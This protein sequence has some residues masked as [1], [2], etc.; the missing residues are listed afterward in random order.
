[1]GRARKLATAVIV[2]T[3]LSGARTVVAQQTTLTGDTIGAPEPYREAVRR[4][5]LRQEPKIVGGKLAPSGA[6][7]WQASLEVAWISDPFRSHYCGGSVLSATWILTAAHCVAGL[8]PEKVTVTA[9]TNVLGVGGVRVN[10]K[11]LIVRADYNKDTSDN[12]IALIEL[13]EPLPVGERLKAIAVLDAKTEGDVL[14]EDTPMTTVGWGRTQEG[15]SVVRD[16]RYAEVPLVPR[17]ACN[18]N[19]SYAGRITENMICAGIT[20]GGVDSCQGDSGGPLSVTVGPS[21]RLAG[22]VSWGEG[23]ARPNK[24]GVYTR[25]AKYADWVSSCLAKPDEC[26]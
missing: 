11:R 22:I 21:A 20:A 9:G 5:L 7:P 16:L 25:G 19:L 3:L 26:R 6:F 13:F 2:A 17:S 8:T 12:D 24:P 18:G 1:M 14:R 15:G 10:T 4:Y 23:C